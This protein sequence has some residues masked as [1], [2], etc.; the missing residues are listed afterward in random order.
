MPLRGVLQRYNIIAVLA[1][2]AKLR[3]G[4]SPVAE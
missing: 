2:I 4:S 1:G 3:D